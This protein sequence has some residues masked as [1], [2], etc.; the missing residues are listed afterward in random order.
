M[1]R[2]N[3]VRRL[4]PYLKDQRRLIVLALV[5]IVLSAISSTALIFLLKTVVDRVLDVSTATPTDVFK[6]LNHGVKSGLPDGDIMA[7]LR[8]IVARGAGAS[9]D[10][11]RL[12]LAVIAILL[13]GVIRGI[14]DFGQT[15]YTQRVGQRVLTRLRADLFEHFQRMS[16]GFFER[17][18][19]GEVISRLTNDLTTLQTLMTTAVVTSI[20]ADRH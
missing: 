14:T 20:S 18:R 5:F 16:V 2:F 11:H 4:K 7:Q 6:A 9:T 12:N 8:A 17:R 15:Y 3:S 10:F 13:V 1:P 19:T